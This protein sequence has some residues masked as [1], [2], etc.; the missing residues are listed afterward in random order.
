MQKIMTLWT[1]IRY[2]VRVLSKNR[3]FTL[4]AVLTL[5][6]S[7]GANTA[8]FSMA[9]AIV[10]H[11]YPFQ[12]LE[13]I[14]ALWETVPAVSTERYGVPPGEYFDWM[15][16]NHA[17]AQMAAYQGWDATLTGAHDSQRVHGFLV[18]PDFFPLLRLPAAKG[19][20]LSG[21]PVLNERSQVVVSH[22]FWQQRLGSDTQVLG[23][24]L[25][26]N[27]LTYTIIGVMPKEMD[28][29][30]YAEV[31]A[32]W[33]V[34]PEARNERTKRELSVIARLKPGV[35][36]AAACAEMNNIGARLAREYP[37]ANAGH[38]VTVMLLRDS[39]DEYAGRFM[40]VVTGAVAFLLL[41]A[42]ANVANLQLA[43]G[44]VRRREM[45][46][47]LALGASRARIARQLI[48]EGIVLAALGAGLG[49]PLAVWGLTV[50][51]ANIPQMVSRH[52]PGLLAGQM[53]SGMLAL[54]L[55]AALLTGVVFT[56]PVALQACSES[57]AV[58]LKEG[59]RG[60]LVGGRRRMRSAL[61][62]SEIGF[63]IV[64][65]IGAGLMVKGFSN[66]AAMKPGFE[67]RD[68][69]TF[70]V[71]LREEK[72]RESYQVVNFYSE[73]LRRIEAIAGTQSAAVVSQLPALADSR[74]S[75]VI[76]EG[77]PVRPP[78][79]PLLA[80][81]Q[82]TSEDYFQTMTVPMLSGRPFLH[83]DTAGGLPVAVI[84]QSAA[85]R[86]WAGQNAIGQRV[87]LA[88]NEL[89]TGWLTIVGV[90]GDV[91]HFLLDSEIRPTIYLPYRQQPIRSLN[92]VMKTRAP[93]TQLAI[94]VRAASQAVDR[95]QPTNDVE[96]LSRFFADLAGGVGVIATLL[97]VFAVIA[98]VLASAGIYAVMAYS[99][100][101]RA[102][103]IG[104]RMAL[105]ARPKDVRRLIV[106]NALCLVGIGLGLGLPAAWALTLAMSSVLPGVVALDPLT[107]ASFSILLATVALL[108]SFIPSHRATRVDPMTALR[109][110]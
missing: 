13:R 5:A 39:V 83:Q 7:I 52:L 106:G 62:I 90:A 6:V 2:A 98:L 49:L 66:L 24:S 36:L 65:L 94:A 91:N 37:V 101:Q 27:G 46:L 53:D 43:R 86:F 68:V 44:A 26:L 14:A 87:R 22:G 42:C 100:A 38:E 29:P 50:I 77:Q 70:S 110:E 59:G 3:G 21:E 58:T 97:G 69:V 17:F 56:V 55:A 61:V 8:I 51:K 15:E 10:F 16:R 18:S 99:V 19:R 79:R 1:D 81:V 11:P 67:P 84:S 72:Y 28:F 108:A 105:G 64:L 74:T 4:V 32:P 23:R 104:I 80:E 71:A 35:S 47:R 109:A 78:D 93:L 75:P 20:F 33:I 34:T 41:L 85:R 96:R 92:L 30:M 63:S 107:F 12:D 54:T 25:E 103:E 60:S 76:M 45:A 40:A 82:V 88:S 95:S 9:D 102:Q 57:L 73:M 89:N 48:T 31:W